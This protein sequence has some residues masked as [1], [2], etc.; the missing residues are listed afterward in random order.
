MIAEPTVD[1]AEVAIRDYSEELALVQERLGSDA[2]RKIDLIEAEIAAMPPVD[3]PLNHVLTPGLYLR[4]VL[5]P[6]GTLLTTRI[7]LTDH[8][9]II[10][11]GVVS[12]WDDER[13]VVT[14]RAPHTGVTKA[15]TRRILYILED[16][17]W[18]T[19]HTREDHET[20][21]DEIVRRITFTGGKYA[22]LGI[23]SAARLTA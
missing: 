18:S 20:D 2:W 1:C 21:P 23:A 7:H 4:E 11:A 3:L 17:I 22:N 15:G 6:K 14:L 16:C 8:P 5:L 9:F 13:G 12:V 19:C 10:S